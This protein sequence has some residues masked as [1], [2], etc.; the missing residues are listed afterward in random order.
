MKVKY[1]SIPEL[2]EVP[3]EIIEAVNNNKLVI[4]I[5]AGVSRIIGCMGWSQLATN[6]IKLCFDTQNKDKTGTCINFKE[7]ESLEQINDHKKVITI[8]YHILCNNELEKEFYNKF[9]KSLESVPKKVDQYNIYKEIFGLRGINITTNAD[10]HFHNQ[11]F[12]ANIVFNEPE[13]LTTSIERTKLYKIHGTQENRESLVFTVPQYIRRYNDDGF[14]LFLKK[15]FDN[16]TVLFL[17]YGMSEFELL[18]FLI[19]KYDSSNEQ[20]EVKHYTL[21]PFYSGE[22]NLLSFEQSYFNDMGIQVIAYQKDENGFNQLYY[23]LKKWN[24]DINQT[25]LYTY[26]SLKEI[27]DLV[28]EL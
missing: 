13:F 28:A 12:S 19:T 24:T 17:G 16:Y 22:E 25:S 1:S 15:I 27:E 23:V 10:I 6:L 9:N 5:G 2:P 20:R 26:D 11:F 8:C 3:T 7:K 18:D 14:K 4:F 21:W